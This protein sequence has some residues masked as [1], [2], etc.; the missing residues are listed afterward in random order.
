VTV[1][2]RTVPSIKC[3]SKVE[4]WIDSHVDL[5]LNPFLIIALNTKWK[6]FIRVFLY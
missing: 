3:V 4:N 5:H 6:H 2:C 1:K